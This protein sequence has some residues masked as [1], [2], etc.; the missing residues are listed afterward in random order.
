M[1]FSPD[2]QLLATGHAGNEVKV[3]DTSTGD[4]LR[5]SIGSVWLGYMQSIAFSPNGHFLAAGSDD[6]TILVWGLEK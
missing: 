1:D 2:G 3:W 6:G 4:L 5:T